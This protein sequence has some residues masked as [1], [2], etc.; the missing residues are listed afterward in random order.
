MSVPGAE[1]K[2]CVGFNMEACVEDVLWWAI[3]EPGFSC[4]HFVHSALMEG[5]S[6]IGHVLGHVAGRF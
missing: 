5:Y 6:K 1:D 3:L 2:H 4:P